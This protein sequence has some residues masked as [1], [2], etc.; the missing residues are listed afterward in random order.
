MRTP[1][2]VFSSH[3]SLTRLSNTCYQLRRSNHNKNPWC[4]NLSKTTPTGCNKKDAKQPLHGPPA[5][6]SRITDRDTNI[7]S[8]HVCTIRHV[9]GTDFQRTI[10]LPLRVVR[11][12]LFRRL[13]VLLFKLCCRSVRRND[14]GD[15]CGVLGVVRTGIEGLST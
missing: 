6:P 8:P 15:G 14:H 11:C 10:R 1:L 9:L 7:Q 4:N 3:H 5:H 12:F 13:R 2:L